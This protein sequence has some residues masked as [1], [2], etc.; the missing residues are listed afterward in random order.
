MNPKISD[1]DMARIF[2]QDDSEAKTKRVVGTYV[3]NGY[4]SPKYALRGKFLV[5]SNVSN[6]GVILLE[7]LS[8]KNSFSHHGKASSLIGYVWEMWIEEKC[9]EIADPVLGDDGSG[10]ERR[11]AKEG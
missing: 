5:K 1:F 8:R 9:L 11:E 6:F 4:M 3:N 10:Q 7:I 2:G